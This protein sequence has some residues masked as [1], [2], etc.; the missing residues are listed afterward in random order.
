SG[1]H[2]RGGTIAYYALSIVSPRNRVDKLVT[3]ARMP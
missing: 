1:G 2:G 3:A